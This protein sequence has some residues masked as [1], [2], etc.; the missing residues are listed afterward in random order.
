MKLNHLAIAIALASVPVIVFNQAQASIN[1]FL[2]KNAL[3]NNV[4]GA[5]SGSVKFAQTHTI[6]AS[7]NSEQEMPRLT[8]TRDTLVMFIPQQQ[9]MKR[10]TLRAYDKSG[11]LLGSLVMN[12]PDRLAKSDR[13]ADSKKPDVVY[14]DEAWS[15][16][17]PADWVQPGLSLEFS[18]DNGRES[19][20][21]KSISGV[22]RRLFY[23][24]SVS[25]C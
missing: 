25:V 12:D 7:G 6:D 10:I 17:L 11:A 15:Q 9:N 3:K 8:S 20:L 16:R 13:P 23:K 19:R 21:K 24:T 2:D 1:V 22:K 5:L 18:A 14:S 4:E